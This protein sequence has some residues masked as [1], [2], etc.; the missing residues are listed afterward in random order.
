MSNNNKG[1]GVAVS[2]LRIEAICRQAPQSV[3]MSEKEILVVEDEYPI[4]EL[5]TFTLGRA[6]FSAREASDAQAAQMQLAQRAPH[7]ILIDWMLPDISGIELTRTLRADRQTR[8]LPVIL[9]TARATEADKIA[10]LE[11]GA[12]DYVTKPFSPRELIAR[13][14]AV[15]RRA[16]NHQINESMH[17]DGLTLDPASHS[18]SVGER[19]LDVGPTEYRLLEFFMRHPERVYSRDQLLDSVWG[20]NVYIEERTVDVHIRRLR[21]VLEDA[22]RDHLIQTVRGVG[23]RFSSRSEGRS[24]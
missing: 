22:K 14:E 11:S 24:D 19:R 4:R 20:A 2:R 3:C 5:I 16:V 10:G 12:D 15:L 9:L 8:E 23:Y 18:V 7:L 1:K 6:G 21:Q 17:M 13:I